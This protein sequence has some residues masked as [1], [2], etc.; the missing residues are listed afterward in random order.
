MLLNPFISIICHLFRLLLEHLFELIDLTFSHHFHHLFQLIVVPI[1]GSTALTE[2]F[3]KSRPS[4]LVSVE[5]I[6][7]L[8]PF[9]PVCAFLNVQ[10]LI[11]LE[12]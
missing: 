8:L 6:C 12:Q 5:D 10:G 9:L 7:H 4:E 3:G 2:Q 1:D 11:D